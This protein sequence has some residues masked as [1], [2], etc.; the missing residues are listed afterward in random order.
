MTTRAER[1]QVLS[2][3]FTTRIS[4]R[5]HRDI[6]RAARAVSLSTGDYTRVVLSIVTGRMD[7]G[8]MVKIKEAAMEEGP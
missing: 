2:T 6:K 1:N 8:V 4:P 3:T 5:L 7:V